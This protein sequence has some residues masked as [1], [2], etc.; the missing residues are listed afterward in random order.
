MAVFFPVNRTAAYAQFGPHPIEMPHADPNAELFLQG[1]LHPM[2]WNVRS[3]TACGLQELAHGWAK[4]GR[5]ATPSVLQRG[6][7]A[8]TD[9]A[10]QLVSR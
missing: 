6:I 3:L 4:F 10:Q 9:I 7:S 5:M 2:T 1:G 8:Q